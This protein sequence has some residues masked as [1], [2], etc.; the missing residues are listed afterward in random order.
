M[1]AKGYTGEPR[2]GDPAIAPY[3]F[4]ASDVYFRM[5]TEHLRDIFVTQMT[6]SV[7]R[8]DAE[9]LVFFTVPEFYYKDIGGAP[10]SY[11]V[12]QRGIEYLNQLFRDAIRGLGA[13]CT[14][15]CLP[16][17]IWWA[18]P[19]AEQPKQL[20]IV[21]NTGPVILSSDLSRSFYWDK[22]NLSTIDGLKAG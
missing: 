5:L 20:A 7:A 9:A 16:G 22:Q 15:V 1:R 10:F 17:T 19:S 8:A 18:Q 14:I 2:P 3:I 11:G 13:R 4:T 6:D 21:H 12:F